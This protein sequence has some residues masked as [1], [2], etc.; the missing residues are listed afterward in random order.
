MLF[1]EN[2]LEQLRQEALSEQS[3]RSQ[4]E[5]NGFSYDADESQDKVNVLWNEGASS[6]LFRGGNEFWNLYPTVN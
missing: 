1:A 2:E 3:V 5:A 6:D 4:T